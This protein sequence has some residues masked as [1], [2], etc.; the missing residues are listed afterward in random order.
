MNTRR[1]ISAAIAALLILSMIGCTTSPIQIL[2][3]AVGAAELVLPLIG[4]AAHIDPA[5]QTAVEGYLSAASG[6]IAQASDILAGPGTDGQKSAAIVA[7]FAGIA[8]PIVPAQ[9][10][11]IAN[12]VQA[13]AQYIAQ[14][15]GSLPAPMAMAHTA[16]AK[17]SVHTLSAS[18]QATLTKIK[19]RALAVR[20][21][22]K[23]H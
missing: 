18:D 17:A 21:A 9:Y 12:A 10:Q 2:D 16:T 3:L 5:V 4:S 23:T 20:A 15:L 8:V 13:L 11:A 22:C 14:F 1:T 7:A 19:A 6:A